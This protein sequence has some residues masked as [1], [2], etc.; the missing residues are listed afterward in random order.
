MSGH[1]CKVIQQS[2]NFLKSC[3]RSF[4]GNF[5][6]NSAY[7]TYLTVGYHYRTKNLIYCK[8]IKC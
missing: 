8:C 6:N 1:H 7:H 4:V 2:K 3:T 5:T